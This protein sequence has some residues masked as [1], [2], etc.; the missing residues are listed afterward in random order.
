[1]LAGA[2]LAGCGTV[3]RQV[4]TNDPNLVVPYL[5]GVHYIQR[6][7]GLTSEL[8]FVVNAGK[9]WA[10][11]KDY[12]GNC[13]RCSY[14]LGLP[15]KSGDS[16]FAASDVTIKRSFRPSE[17]SFHPK[18]GRVT[19]TTRDAGRIVVDVQIDDERVPRLI[20]GTYTLTEDAAGYKSEQRR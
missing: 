4:I 5:E 19:I 15:N 20:N 14:S 13:D 7:T 8:V 10:G 3:P 16:T 9:D 18:S 17:Q 12:F 1:M 6:S 11:K 2:L